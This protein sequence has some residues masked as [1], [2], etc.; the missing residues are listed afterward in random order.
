MIVTCSQTLVGIFNPSMSFNGI[1]CQIQSY[2]LCF[3]INNV[4]YSFV[5]QGLFQLCRV[6]FHQKLFLQTLR[7][8]I[9]A[10][11]IQWLFVCLTNLIYFLFRDFEYIDSEYRC[12]IR[13]TNLRA[14]FMLF[15]TAYGIP[16]NILFMIYFVIIRHIR[17][18][19]LRIQNRPHGK[20]R[21]MIVLKRI[22]LVFIALQLI[23]TPL[24]VLS[25][26]YIVTGHIVELTYQIQNLTLAFSQLFLP[27]LMTLGIPQIRE[28]FKRSQHKVHPIIRRNIPLNELSARIRIQRF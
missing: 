22:V 17:Q 21:D 2:F 6:V 18:R 13:F 16:G 11:I 19:N 4:T 3:F 9:I 25:I 23:S 15:V 24:A 10:M 14:S 1:F 27:I 28:K 5:I 7:I 26:I 12:L 8:F 20:K